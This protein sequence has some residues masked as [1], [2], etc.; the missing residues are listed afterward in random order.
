MR[1]GRN[2][3]AAF[4]VGRQT[5]RGMAL[6]PFDYRLGPQPPQGK[7]HFVHVKDPAGDGGPGA[8]VEQAEQATRL[9]R[10]GYDTS[11]LLFPPPPGEMR[12]P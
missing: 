7:V 12:I 4:P 2:V 9:K 1:I 6:K 10:K 11:V 5:F 3:D 8:H